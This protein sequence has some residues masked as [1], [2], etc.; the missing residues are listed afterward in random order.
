MPAFATSGTMTAVYPG[1][2]FYCVNNAA[3]DAGITKT[4][5]FAI[6][7]NADGSSVPLTIVN[8]TNQNATGQASADPFTDGSYQND[9]GMLV[10]AGAA[11][12]YNL[13]SGFFRFTFASAPTSGSL[14]VQR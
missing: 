14:I 3:T 13:S 2:T 6:G 4:L 9:S 12:Q 1:D 11:L 7:P 10:S 5:Q 8:T